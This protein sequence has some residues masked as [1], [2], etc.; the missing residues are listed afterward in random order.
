MGG[1][2]GGSQRKREL[3]AHLFTLPLRQI[4]PPRER[5]AR[6]NSPAKNFSGRSAARPSEIAVAGTSDGMLTNEHK[7][8]VFRIDKFLVDT[9]SEKT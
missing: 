6:E 9:H 8:W 3:T 4:Q 5:F 7:R 2:D 1:G